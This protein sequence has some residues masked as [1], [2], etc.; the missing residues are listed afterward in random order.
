MF[1]ICNLMTLIVVFCRFGIISY[2]HGTR[3]I[4]ATLR[5]SDSIHLLYGSRILYSITGQLVLTQKASAESVLGWERFF[6]LL[7]HADLQEDLL[8]CRQQRLGNVDWHPNHE[9]ISYKYFERKSHQRLSRFSCG[10][11]IL[12]ELEFGNVGFPWGKKTRKPG[13]LGQTLGERREPT[14]NSTQIWSRVSRNRTRSI[15][16]GGENCF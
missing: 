2:L 12:V 3:L 10:S 1:W 7:L 14:T 13:E 15:L 16:V 11:S 9:K 8:W 4:T 6:A 5:R